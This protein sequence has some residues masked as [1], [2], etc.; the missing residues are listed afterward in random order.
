M[1]EILPKISS[2]TPADSRGVILRLL[3][4]A[5]SLPLFE[6]LSANQGIL[7]SPLLEVFI[8]SFLHSVTEVI[9]GGLLK[10][11]NVDEDDLQFVRGR[12]VARRQF[13]A[14]ANRVDKVAC[15][16]DLLTSDNYWNQIIKSAVVI[17]GPWLES[18]PMRSRWAEIL[19]AF[20]GIASI[21]L[22]RTAINRLPFD[23][24]AARYRVPIQW[25]KWIQQIVSPDLRSGSNIA[26]GLLVDMNA[27]FERAIASTITRRAWTSS[28]LRVSTQEGRR[29]L[30]RHRTTRREA[31]RLIPDVTIRDASRVVGILDTKWKLVKRRRDRTLFPSAN[32]LNQMQAYSIAHKC[33]QLYLIYPWYEKL[34]GSRESSFELAA[35]E[36]IR[37][38]V[39]VICVD[40]TVDDYPIVIGD[41]QGDLAI[42]FSV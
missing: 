5:S 35:H 10:Q 2:A 14:N 4:D 39:K 3:R 22:R 18:I 6:T 40:V 30:A 13:S 25:A 32:D 41:V 9:R 29:F 28:R 33:D 7:N 36:R 23:R 20:D 27:L 16:F 1:L 42:L 12:I 21:D 17:V 24:Q 37:P 11:Y 31:Y 34:K 38:V 15:R 19:A 26:P 8:S